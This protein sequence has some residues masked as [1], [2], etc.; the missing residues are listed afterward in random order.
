VASARNCRLTTPGEQIFSTVVYQGE[1]HHPNFRPSDKK[2][3]ILTFSFLSY[4]SEW[5]VPHFHELLSSLTRAPLFITILLGANDAVLPGL[6]QHVPLPK[7]KQNIR[8]FVD[9][10][11]AHPLTKSTKIILITP[12]PIDVQFREV[13]RRKSTPRAAQPD[14]PMVEAEDPIAIPE[15]SDEDLKDFPG[16]KTWMNKLE[17]A[18][19]IMEIGADYKKAGKEDT[20]EALNFWQALINWGVDKG[21]KEG[22]T[23]AEPLPGCGLPGAVEFGREVLRDGLHFGPIVSGISFH[24]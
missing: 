6:A 9:L 24:V 19:A 15:T 5:L 2:G 20:V 1:S 12:P 10:I 8:D 13:W 18:A 16:Y 7:F 14:S 4:N 17:Y 11:I 21:K 23:E 3:P 22:K